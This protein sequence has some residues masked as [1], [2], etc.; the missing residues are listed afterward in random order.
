MNK[1]HAFQIKEI[2][3]ID[4]MFSDESSFYAIGP[5]GERQHIQNEFYF[6]F[7]PEAGHWCIVWEHGLV[8][9][10][11][12]ETFQ[13][14]FRY[15]GGTQFE[16]EVAALFLEVRS[17]PEWKVRKAAEREERRIRNEERR[18]KAQEELEEAMRNPVQIVNGLM[19]RRVFPGLMPIP[20]GIQVQPMSKHISALPI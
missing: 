7:K 6:L 10:R 19:I 17:T 11:P 16:T 9:F 5:K 18:V 14:D 15:I 8:T 1:V 20:E 13:R 4:W 2:D 12:N 3:K